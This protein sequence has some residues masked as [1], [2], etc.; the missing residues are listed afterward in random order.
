MGTKNNPKNRGA[1]GEKKKY[2]GKELEPVLYY[3]KHAG[4]GKYMTAR[5]VKTNEMVC[6]KNGK[7]MA[8][9]EIVGE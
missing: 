3:G 1:E 6:D 8:W 9:D 2:K 4:H 7:P 5:F